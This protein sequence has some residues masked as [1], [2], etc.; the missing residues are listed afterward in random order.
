M[1]ELVLLEVYPEVECIITTSQ[2]ADILAHLDSSQYTAPIGQMSVQL[3]APLQVVS[4]SPV[5]SL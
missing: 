4:A 1:L 5:G 3:L 2:E